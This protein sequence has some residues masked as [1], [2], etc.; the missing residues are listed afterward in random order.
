[1]DQTTPSNSNSLTLCYS[2]QEFR[3]LE[4]KAIDFHPSTVNCS[5]PA[6]SPER[7]TS[8]LTRVSI[9]EWLW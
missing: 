1:M 8:Q 5:I 7:E 6:P 4:V 2:S 9:C 3:N